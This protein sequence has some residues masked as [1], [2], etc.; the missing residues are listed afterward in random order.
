M[1]LLQH[2]EIPNSL[3]TGIY[4]TGSS[5][6]CDPPVLDTDIDFIIHTTDM[7]GLL[8]FLRENNYCSSITDEGEYE[9]ETEGFECLRHGNINLILTENRVFYSRWVRATQ[10]AKQFNLL[11]K[12]D[13]I[14]LF[15]EVIYSDGGLKTYDSPEEKSFY[16]V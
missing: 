8:R 14:S 3:W 4:K 10:L 1:E 5:V 2:I 12:T 7:E 9:L 13:R 15:Q 16:D 11:K 6:I